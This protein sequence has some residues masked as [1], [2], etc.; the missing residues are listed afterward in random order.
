MRLVA[1][2]RARFDELLHGDDWCRHRDISFR[3]CLW[4]AD[5]ASDTGTV[6]KRTGL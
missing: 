3:L 2:M 5:D 4:E 6:P 1:E